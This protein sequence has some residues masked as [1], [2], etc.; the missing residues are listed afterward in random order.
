MTGARGAR[1]ERRASGLAYGVERFCHQ[2]GRRG[3]SR[4]L[5]TALLTIVTLHFRGLTTNLQ[6][7]FSWTAW[8]A[9][10][11][12][13]GSATRDRPS[14]RSRLYREDAMSSRRRAR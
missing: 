9:G 3:L 1:L 4:S 5:S 13:R 12:A 10:V 8:R 14:A 2:H 11:E 7:E 6:S